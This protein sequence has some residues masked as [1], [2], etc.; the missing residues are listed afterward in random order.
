METIKFQLPTFELTSFQKLVD[1]MKTRTNFINAEFGKPYKKLYTHTEI[2]E[3]GI[4]RDVKMWHEVVDV[5]VEMN[6][7]NEWVLLASYKDGEEYVANPTKELVFQNPEHGKK[8][9][10]C[11]VCGHWC[12]NSFLVYNSET[13]EELQVGKEC[14]KTFGLNGLDFVHEFT[15]SLF[16]VF[17]I[18]CCGDEEFPVWKGEK[19]NFAFSSCKTSDLIKAAKTYYN[20]N[21]IWKKGEYQNGVYVR[22]ESNITI[23][24]I[25]EQNKFEGD[26]S[27]VEKIIEHVKSLEVKS[28]FSAEMLEMVENFYSTPS[29]APHAFFAVK[30]YEDSLKAKEFNME[31]YQP[32]LQ[33]HVT[34]KVI[35]VK[36]LD[37]FYGVAKKYTIEGVN[38]LVFERIGKVD[39][40]EN[41][42][43]DFYSIIKRVINNKIVLDRT[44]KKPK[45]GI[46]IVE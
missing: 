36:T 43:V 42:T 23:Q 11:D 16:K 25:L 24:N 44:T 8:Y 19:D 3:D 9:T 5:T 37:S 41:D 27:Y 20:D 26:D 21:K 46:E 22:S 4:C 10:K 17:K 31:K 7:E 30:S 6:T 45:K 12:K 33:I 40:L 2:D 34:G 18:Y 39:V 14:L 28:E 13:G 15:T 38:G 35:D 1:K 32:G 29:K